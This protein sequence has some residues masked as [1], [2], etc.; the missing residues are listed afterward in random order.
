[1]EFEQKRQFVGENVFKIIAS[2]PGFPK[3]DQ[4]LVSPL[5]RPEAAK[6]L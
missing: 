3:F 5:R 1:M 4:K 6:K 2:G